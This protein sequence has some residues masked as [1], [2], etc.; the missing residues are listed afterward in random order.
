MI[1]KL[2][3]QTMNGV[4]A[5]KI[6]KAREFARE[7]ITTFAEH[8]RDDGIDAVQKTWEHT[9]SEFLVYAQRGDR[10]ETT[11]EN[12]GINGEEA[13]R[14]DRELHPTLYPGESQK[15]QTHAGTVRRDIPGEKSKAGERGGGIEVGIG[16]AGTKRRGRGMADTYKE[17]GRGCKEIT[18]GAGLKW[19]V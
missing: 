10:G 14:T 15:Q 19:E 7:S 6:C 12:A 5:D 4:E 2:E 17:G 3:V 18:G 9:W 16:K 8:M 11:K 13:T 1:N